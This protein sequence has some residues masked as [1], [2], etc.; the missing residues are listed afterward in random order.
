MCIR[1]AIVSLLVSGLGLL[2]G[3][4][5]ADPHPVC[6][7]PPQGGKAF[8]WDIEYDELDPRNGDYALRLI[9]PQF[10]NPAESPT[11]QPRGFIVL[12]GLTNC[13]LYRYKAPAAG[14]YVPK[15][16]TE[17]GN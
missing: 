15:T 8:A 10:E 13:K 1:L 6:N 4:A 12:T 14:F 17:G 3:V 9:I 2:N 7:K 16:A 5:S 11:T